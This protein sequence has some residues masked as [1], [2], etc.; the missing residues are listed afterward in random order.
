MDIEETGNYLIR[1]V[2]RM[3][4]RLSEVWFEMKLYVRSIRTEEIVTDK[5]CIGQSCIT[6]QEFTEL[7]ELRGQNSTSSSSYTSSSSSSS[8]SS[9]PPPESN[10]SLA[11]PIPVIESPSE[12]GTIPESSTTDTPSEEVTQ[13]T[14]SPD[15]VESSPSVSSE[16]VF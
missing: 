6:E 9:S 1:L 5:L 4:E 10:T 2:K 16:A 14:S 3:I 13:P 8:S 7:M 15:G 11:N 12:S